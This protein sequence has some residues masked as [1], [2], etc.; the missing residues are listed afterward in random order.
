MTGIV[1]TA[2]GSG[3]A[4][5]VEPVAPVETT[6][7]EGGLADAGADT[8]FLIPDEVM[9]ASDLDE[10]TLPAAPAAKTEPEA[11]ATT[12]AKPTTEAKPAV[13]A[14]AAKPATPAKAGDAKPEVKPAET[15]PAET[16]TTA[17][18][19]AA[20]P[21][22]LLE[23]VAKNRDA[24]IS[25]LAESRFKLSKEE[26]DLLDTD[27][28]AAIQKIAA[29]TY[30]EATTSTLNLMDK[31]VR[32]QLPQLIEQHTQTT[33]VYKSTEDDFYKEWPNLDRAADEKTV[34]QYANI[35][36]QANPSAT[37]ADAIRAVG[38]IVSSILNKPK[39]AAA[40]VPAAKPNGPRPFTPASGA[41]RVV[42]QTPVPAASPFA[43]LGEEFE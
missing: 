18:P 4:A 17:K 10:V 37:K 19:T 34:N 30:Y 32:E 5:S 8:S 3:E 26:S 42:S 41:A 43:G 35:Y 29:R 39:V 13:P 31:F 36:R 6:P 27:A 9:S 15:N 14:A 1:E 25:H 16:S 11:P 33:Q 2:P 22:N 12:A 38:T 23:E 20:P 7:G 40:A 24:I 28:N 21:V